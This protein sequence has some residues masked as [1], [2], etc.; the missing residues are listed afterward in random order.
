MSKKTNDEHDIA[1]S[2]GCFFFTVNFLS[3]LYLVSYDYYIENS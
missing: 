1:F 2:K 3:F